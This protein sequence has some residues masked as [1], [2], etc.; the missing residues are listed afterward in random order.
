MHA[1][2]DLH[3][4]PTHEAHGRSGF[5]PPLGHDRCVD[6]PYREIAPP[7]GLAAYVDRFWTRASDAAEAPHRVLPDGCVDLLVDLR[8]GTA[9]LVGPMTRA[10]LVPG[11]PA[12]VIAARFRPGAGERAMGVPLDALA[13]A[14]VSLDELGIEAAPLIDA[15]ADAHE[16]DRVPIVAAFVRARLARAEP[17]DR[18][19]QRAVTRLAGGSTRV[20]TLAAELGVSRQYLARVFARDVG[21]SPKMLARI[22]RMQRVMI[23]ITQ[24][25][26]DWAALAHELGFADQAHLAHD[27]TELAGLSPT[28]LAAE[29][30]IS[31][32]A[33]IYG[34]VEGIP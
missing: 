6:A 7:A 26:R 8:A 13:D 29:G 20:A 2:R 11:D 33:S 27:A 25:R 32:I 34:G 31:A 14:S 30:S 21:V 5:S 23:A 16:A 28:R 15:L 19:V 17:I 24:G 4:A 22:A 3:R 12:S 18:L 1:W 9:E 10:A